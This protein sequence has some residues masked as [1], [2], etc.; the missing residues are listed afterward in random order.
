MLLPISVLG[1]N[2][3][4][5]KIHLQSRDNKIRRGNRTV[6]TDAKKLTS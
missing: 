4:M 6:G 1:R 3:L 5:D 2:R